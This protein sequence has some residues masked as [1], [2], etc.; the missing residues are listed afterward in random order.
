MNSGNHERSTFALVCGTAAVCGMPALGCLLLGAWG[1]MWADWP[2]IDHPHARVTKVLGVPY[3]VC[4]RNPDGSVRMYTMS[5]KQRAS[6]LKKPRKPTAWQLLRYWWR[7]LRVIV[8]GGPPDGA[9]YTWRAFPGHQIHLLAVASSAAVF[10]AWSTP[11]DRRDS[12]QKF[13][14]RFRTHRGLTHSVWFG[15]GTA[16]VVW[17]A[18]LGLR[19]FVV[20]TL[21]GLS[22]APWEV[23]FGTRH[24]I[25]LLV[26]TTFY[27]VLGHIL[28]DS[29]TDYCT[30][31]LGPFVKIRGRRYYPMSLVP[32]P[33]RFKVNHW[34]ED[35]P[36]TWACWTS[37]VAASLGALG[38][39]VPILGMV[40]GLWTHLG[41]A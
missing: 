12:T 25:E 16:L 20:G 13:G 26:G 6:Y 36:V 29:C 27:G 23:I 3:R 10:D 2:D 11:A 17:P 15:I 22:S 35:G 9:R 28:G 31:P 14:I 19:H 40:Q 33:F 21:P 8:T 1:A 24:V 4:K 32:E 38:W 5:E 37:A 41:A 30:A 39:L 18:L 34:V 7:R